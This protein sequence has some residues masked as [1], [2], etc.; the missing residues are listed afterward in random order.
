MFTVYPQSLEFVSV[1]G[2]LEC[3]LF[4]LN[5]PV[6]PFKQFKSLFNIILYG[7]SVTGGDALR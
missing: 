2:D 3:D 1:T 4:A 7:F 5:V 6:T